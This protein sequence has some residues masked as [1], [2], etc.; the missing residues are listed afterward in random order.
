M[1]P[2][3]LLLVNLAQGADRCATA[4]LT[5]LYEGLPTESFARMPALAERVKGSKETDVHR[6]FLELS[7]YQRRP[8]REYYKSLA[9][10]N[11]QSEDHQ[12]LYARSLVGSNTPEALKLYAS[13]LAKDP[14]YPWVHLSQLEIYRAPAFRDR[15]KLAASFAVIRRVC[16]ALLKPFSYLSEVTENETVAQ[17]ARDLRIALKNVAKPEEL[18]LY[19]TLW[20]AEFRLLP[21]GQHE[22]LRTQIGEDLKRLLA[23]PK[24]RQL[25]SVLENGAKLSG[26]TA[27]TQRL[28]AERPADPSEILMEQSNAW[29]RDHPRPKPDAAPE[30]KI[31][32]GK[33]LAPKAVEWMKIDP[34]S[35]IGQVNAV[36]ALVF[37]KAPEHEIAQAGDALAKFLRS[38]RDV[39]VSWMVSLARLYVEH[40][41]LLDRVEGLCND[42]IHWLDDPEAVIEIDLAPSPQ[43]TARNREFNLNW[44]VDALVTI[45]LLYEKQGRRDEAQATLWRASD[46]LTSKSEGKETEGGSLHRARYTLVRTRAEM[47]EREGRKLDALAGYREGAV[48]FPY[49]AADLSARQR[50][51][52]KE[53]GGTDEGWQQWSKPVADAVAKRPS[54]GPAIGSAEKRALPPLNARDLNGKPW[55][56]EQFAG[57]TTVAAVWATWCQPCRA[58]LPYISKLA[59]KL[60]D[61]RDVQV[62]TFN[63]DENIG[64]AEAFTKAQGYQFPVVWAKQ[65]AEDLMPMFVIPRT[66]VI[67]DGVITKEYQGFGADG[68]KWLEQV[69]T[70][71][72]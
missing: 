21:S 36:V 64:I 66:W 40:G 23:L 48:L 33:L 43:M 7:V 35:V 50:R 72:K 30:S 41:V 42:V 55:T 29:I 16:P 34:D 68:D 57:K 58:E 62:I 14:E 44:S 39:S 37:Q 49:A 19:S 11:P 70:E 45:A 32:Y 63:T 26:D 59:E 5:S 13:I 20:A 38:R 31:A 2:I 1:V 65:Y 22:P 18:R 6:A 8:E 53:L 61:R 52:W 46:Y 17:A 3:L 24:D 69:L 4:D 12:Y 10:S 15:A 28:T 67:K 56:L 54:Q 47:A 51:L 9:E 25:H 71:L 60:K 27:L